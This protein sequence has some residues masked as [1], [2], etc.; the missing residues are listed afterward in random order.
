MQNDTKGG[1][2]CSAPRLLPFSSTSHTGSP[3]LPVSRNND[4][5]LWIEVDELHT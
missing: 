3:L 1:I 4:V 5:D 2:L